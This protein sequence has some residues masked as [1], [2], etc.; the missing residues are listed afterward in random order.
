MPEQTPHGILEVTGNKHT[1]HWF[2]FSAIH[3]WYTKHVGGIKIKMKHK[4]WLCP[5]PN[6]NNEPLKHHLVLMHYSYSD[7]YGCIHHSVSKSDINFVN[8][9][10]LLVPLTSVKI[11]T[12]HEWTWFSSVGKAKLTYSMNI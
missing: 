4:F 6:L 9:K 12:E 10:L 7:S 8:L 11:K 1:I 3:N 2:P 5:N